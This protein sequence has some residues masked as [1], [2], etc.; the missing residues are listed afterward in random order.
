MSRRANRAYAR[1][2]GAARRPVHE[3]EAGAACCATCRFNR[4]LEG[5]HR[6]AYCTIRDLPLT[7][8]AAS[9][10][11]NH[12]KTNPRRL[13]LPIGPVRGRDVSGHVIVI[14][15]SLDTRQIRNGLIELLAGIL[16]LPP[17][18]DERIAPCDVAAI[19]H[20]RDLG[21]LR[22]VPLLARVAAWPEDPTCPTRRALRRAAAVLVAAV[23]RIETLEQPYPWE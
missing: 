15:P 7:A 10:C 2:E 18:A 9:W 21:E 20:V 6:R 17:L 13:T 3:R 23:G 4:S 11:A 12:P 22:A 5:G 19:G 14:A 16:A 1:R 8:P